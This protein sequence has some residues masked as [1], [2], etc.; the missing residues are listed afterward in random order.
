MFRLPTLPTLLAAS[1]SVVLILDLGGISENL[2]SFH[3]PPFT[4]CISTTVSMGKAISVHLSMGLPLKYAT[5]HCR[6]ET[7]ETTRT[8][9]ICCSMSIT[10]LREGGP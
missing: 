5:R 2:F 3:M 8:G 1:M 9:T 7:W 6:T 10:Q 4:G